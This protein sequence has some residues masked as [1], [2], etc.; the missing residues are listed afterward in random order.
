MFPAQAGPV[1]VGLAG[2][3]GGA[4]DRVAPRRVI[5]GAA[6]LGR[7]WLQVALL[8]GACH[9][10]GS[11]AQRRNGDRFVCAQPDLL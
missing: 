6:G 2:R 7:L 5:V 11:F 4:S 9:G 3:I 8:L 10:K 1:A